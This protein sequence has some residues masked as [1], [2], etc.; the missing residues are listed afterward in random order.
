MLLVLPEKTSTTNSSIWRVNIIDKKLTL[1][2]L[3]FGTNF[4]SKSLISE[5]N[6]LVALLEEKKKWD[7]KYKLEIS[8]IWIKINKLAVGKNQTN[9]LMNWPPPSN[10]CWYVYHPKT[11]F[12]RYVK[13]IYTIKNN[14]I[15]R[16]NYFWESHYYSDAPPPSLNTR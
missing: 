14:F 13:I 9:H 12:F 11:L 15:W 8:K 1:F 3:R 6:N 4:V 2:F 7:E 10:I 16:T 5:Y